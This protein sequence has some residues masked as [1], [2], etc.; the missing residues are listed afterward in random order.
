MTTP[1]HPEKSI[2]ENPGDGCPWG[3]AG[4]KACRS[5]SVCFLLCVSSGRELSLSTPLLSAFLRIAIIGPTVP[6]GPA[7]PM[8]VPDE[9]MLVR[10][11]EIRTVRGEVHE[12]RLMGKDPLP[13]LCYLS[14]M[15]W[16][17]VHDS[18]PVFS[19]NLSDIWTFDA[20]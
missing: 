6:I 9:N 13:R 10:R 5:V 4:G 8:T 20:F 18:R 19:W 14:R 17:R 7:N 2:F 12:D 11:M 16:A 1:S 3:V 15:A